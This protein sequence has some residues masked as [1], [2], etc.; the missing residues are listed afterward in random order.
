MRF[1]SMAMP[2]ST[3]SPGKNMWSRSVRSPVQDE[4]A[5]RGSSDEV[6]VVAHRNGLEVQVFR[7]FGDVGRQQIEHIHMLDGPQRCIDLVV[8]ESLQ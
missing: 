1:S 3:C 5:P 8:V 4:H 2:F 6:A 7:L